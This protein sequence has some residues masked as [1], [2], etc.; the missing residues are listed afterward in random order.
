MCVEFTSNV[1][2][3]KIEPGMFRAGAKLERRRS[4]LECCFYRLLEVFWSNFSFPLVDVFWQDLRCRRVTTSLVQIEATERRI[5][6]YVG[7][8][9]F[10]NL[11]YFN[12][13]F[14]ESNERLILDKKQSKIWL[15]F[16]ILPER[17][18]YWR[19]SLHKDVPDKCL[20]RR[21]WCKIRSCSLKKWS[22]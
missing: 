18:F 5:E 22:F 8:I 15:W 1:C 7:K 2:F 16:E 20:E 19:Q 14:H 11:K 6:S 13:V 9:W 17:V 3:D 10:L 4:R 21:I 12:S